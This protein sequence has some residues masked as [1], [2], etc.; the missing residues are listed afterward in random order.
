[1]RVDVLGRSLGVVDAS[2][3][4]WRELETRLRSVRMKDPEI[5]GRIEAAGEV[6]HGDVIRALDTFLA[7]DFRNVQFPGAAGP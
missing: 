6:L 3:G 5:T 4:V 7:A 2:E 1:M